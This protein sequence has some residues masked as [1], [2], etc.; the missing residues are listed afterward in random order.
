VTV[1]LLAARVVTT[2]ILYAQKEVLANQE[3]RQVVFEPKQNRYRFTD[4]SGTA[5][6]VD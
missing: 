5:I 3:F 1:F 4:G 2:D 6:A